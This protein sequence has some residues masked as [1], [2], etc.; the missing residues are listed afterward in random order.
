MFIRIVREDKMQTAIN[1]I[2]D[3]MKETSGA[4]EEHAQLTEQLV[5]LNDAKV[6]KD[7]VNVKVKEA[8]LVGLA[9]FAGILTIV[10]YEQIG[11]V[12]SKA[13]SLLLK[14]KI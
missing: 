10:H 13:L 3:E 8:A 12:T 4:S 2:L 7:S 5:K 6:S 11:V 14:A 1:D 9:N